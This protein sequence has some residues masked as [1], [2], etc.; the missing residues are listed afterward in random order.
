MERS[1]E[2]TRER[3][4]L[5]IKGGEAFLPIDKVVEGIPFE[6]LGERPNELPYSF[7]EQFYHTYLAQKDLLE[8][9]KDSFHEA[10][11]WPDDYW[12]ST[13][14]PRDE[15][16]WEDLKK[17]Y[18]SDRDAFCDLLRDPERDLYEPFQNGSGHTL[19]R[20]SLLVIEH[21]A[22]HTGQLMII[23]RELKL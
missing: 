16:E 20:Q 7:Y 6:K 4:I 9:S 19:M 13:P 11:A 21:A 17:A 2:E 5:H 3:L 12:P 18:F 8:Y 23:K 10:G 14:G 1:E 15:Q 22:Y